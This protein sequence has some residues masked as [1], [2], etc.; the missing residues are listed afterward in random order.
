[1]SSLH[2]RKIKVVSI[3]QKFYKLFPEEDE[4][5]RKLGQEAKE[6]PCLILLKLTYKRKKYTFAIPFRLNIGN[7][8]KNTYFSLP[9]RK[10]TR[11]GRS[12]R[13]HYKRC[14]LS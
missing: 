5:M 10:T 7:A 9:K 2:K 3:S 12:H 11:E 14:F 1:M 13:L 6:R 4:I 8:L